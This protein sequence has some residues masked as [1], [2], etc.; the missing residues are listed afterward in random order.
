MIEKWWSTDEI[1][2]T[3]DIHSVLRIWMT[4]V[5]MFEML[6]I[7]INV[8]FVAPTTNTATT[9]IPTPTILLKFLTDFKSFKF[10]I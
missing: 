2:E 1:D 5:R 9:A 4:K 7:D 8:T 6:L 3:D 10:S